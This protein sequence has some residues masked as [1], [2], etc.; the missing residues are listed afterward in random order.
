MRAL[1][2]IAQSLRVG[3]VHPTTVINTLI[4]TENDGGL[5]AIEQLKTQLEQSLHALQE[6]RHPHSQMIKAWLGAVHN[7]LQMFRKAA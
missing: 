2:I 1:E 4:E 7:Y 3:Y 6:R 5:I